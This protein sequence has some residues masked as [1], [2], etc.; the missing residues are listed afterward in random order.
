MAQGLGASV[1]QQLDIIAQ[2]LAGTVKLAFNATFMREV[3]DETARLIFIRTRLGYGVP[4]QGSQR[5][6]LFPLSAGYI[7]M[8]K[9]SQKNGFLSSATTASKSN[10]TFTGQLLESI[11]TKKAQDGISWVGPIGYRKEGG[12]NEQVANTVSKT[13]P[14]MFL[15]DL[16]LKKI[17][18][19][20]QNNFSSVFKTRFT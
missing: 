5:Q 1:K 7:A 20:A 8:R 17:Q 18:R 19:F 6:K 15:S 3:G 4:S 14:F 10:L 2:K 12:T 16:E 11:Q 13:R 9:K